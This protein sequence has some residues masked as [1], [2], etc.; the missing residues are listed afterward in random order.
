MLTVKL[1][2]R[3]VQ[4]KE[5][6][7]SVNTQYFRRRAGQFI[8]SKLDF[9]NCAFAII[10]PELDGYQS[11][12]DLP[13]FDFRGD[14]N[15][16][17]FLEIVKQKSFY[18][19]YGEQANGSRKAKRINPGVFFE[20]PICLPCIDEQNKIAEFLTALDDKIELAGRELAK[21][22]EFKQGLLQQMFV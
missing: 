14:I 7:G 4:A 11:T 9:L 16:S 1:W 15:K 5:A 6:T 3:G 12:L 13:A 21:A 20:M 22:Q 19:N 2:G 18:K 17:L 8:Y 10:P